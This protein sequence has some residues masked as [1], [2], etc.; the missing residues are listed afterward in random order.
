[1]QSIRSRNER[2]SI[3]TCTCVVLVQG[4][5]S[6]REKERA[7]RAYVIRQNAVKISVNMISNTGCVIIRIVG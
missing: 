4:N 6:I 3:H 5:V 7:E 1:M 2:V